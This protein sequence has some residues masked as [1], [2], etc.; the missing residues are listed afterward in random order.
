M[1]RGL[2]KTQRQ[3]LKILRVGQH[4]S[5]LSLVGTI[6]G[7]NYDCGQGSAGYVAT[8]VAI[9]SLVKRGFVEK[10]HRVEHGHSILGPYHNQVLWVKKLSI[11]KRDLILKETL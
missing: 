9:K 5:F 2:G 4:M 8:S 3:I 11:K 6:Y 1:S 7:N 10:V